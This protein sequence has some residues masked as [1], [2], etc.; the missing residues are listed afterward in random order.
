MVLVVVV[1]DTGRCQ[2]IQVGTLLDTRSL[3][4]VNM[5]KVLFAVSA[6]ASVD[7]KRNP[8]RKCLPWL[9]GSSV[10]NYPTQ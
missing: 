1:V 2:M 6:V 3:V 8:V 4:V 10:F 7:E 9:H 5:N